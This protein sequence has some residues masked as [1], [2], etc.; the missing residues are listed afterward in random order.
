MIRA[1]IIDVKE[2]TD[3]NLYQ[4][5]KQKSFV[6]PFAKE[7]NIGERTLSRGNVVCGILRSFRH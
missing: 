4:T 2:L 1:G 3:H 7:Y 6:T 5:N